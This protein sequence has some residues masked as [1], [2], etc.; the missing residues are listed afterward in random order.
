MKRCIIAA[1]IV[2]AVLAV[3][4]TT[5][6]QDRPGARQ[7][8]GFE[9][10]R[11]RIQNM[12]PEEREKFRADM[13]ERRKRWEGMSEA[14]REKFRAEMLER[15]GSGG[16]PLGSE[17][18]LKAIKAIE[19]QV[20]KLKA[21]VTEGAGPQARQR[22][23]DLSEEQRAKL[24]EKMA[25]AMRQRQQTI[26]AI[27]EQLAKLR[28][29]GQ[30]RQQPAM[31]VRELRAIHELAVKEKASKTADRLEKLIARYQREPRDRP[32]EPAE[33]RPRPQREPG[34]RPATR[35]RNRE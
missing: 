11:Q 4:W 6:G 8:E 14:E 22:L 24:R 1:A 33:R 28:G 32:Q 16:R 7:G 19:E 3:A 30:P 23:R 15:F 31:P 20:A 12:S 25:A 27:E 34:E 29:A 17:D 18:Q 2:L 5:F 10:I 13:L 21:A 35:E 26:R 9:A